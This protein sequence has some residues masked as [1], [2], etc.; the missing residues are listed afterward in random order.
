[1]QRIRPFAGEDLRGFRHGRGCAVF[2][3]RQAHHDAA[4]PV[5]TFFFGCSFAAFPSPPSH[6]GA[7]N[8]GSGYGTC[9]NFSGPTRGSFPCAFSASARSTLSGVI[10][11]SSIRTPTAS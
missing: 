4:T 8:I 9:G 7:T 10:G 5:R 1:R 11:T 2:E 3:P 6:G